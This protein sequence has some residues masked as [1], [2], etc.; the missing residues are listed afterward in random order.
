MKTKL[1]AIA[2]L[3]SSGLTTWAWFPPSITQEKVN[4]IQIGRTTETDLV[5]LFGAPTTRRVDLRG[6]VEL[7]WFRSK[8]IPPQGYLPLIGSFIGGLDIDSQQL[9]VVLSPRGTVLRFS[10]Y[11]SATG[12]RAPNQTPSRRHSDYAR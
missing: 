7:D 12:L 4:Q 3:I 9:A 1:L 10:A 8:P 11:S 6:E 5:R 2:L